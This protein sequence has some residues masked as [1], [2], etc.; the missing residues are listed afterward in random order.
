MAETNWSI[1]GEERASC[2]CDW[3]CPCQFNAVPTKGNCDALV[4]WRIDKGHFGG[5]SLDG[6]V[7]ACVFSFPGA[8]HE[9]NGKILVIVDDKAT[10]E[11]RAAIEALW[12]GQHGG[13]A[14]EIFSSVAPNKLGTVSSPIEFESDREARVGKISVPGVGET[15]VGPRLGTPR[16]AP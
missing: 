2:N 12:T 10:A 9:G 13:A 15:T 3:G 6:I 7:F 14:F 5:T 11:Q 16:P 8:V 4:A 1:S